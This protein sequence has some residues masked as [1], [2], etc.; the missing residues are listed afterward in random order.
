M[1]QTD[2]IGVGLIGYGLGGQACHAPYIRS[3]AGM[4]LQAVVS[5]DAAKIPADMPDTL[6]VPS[7]DALLSEPGIGLVVIS[8]PDDLH[9]EHALAA[10]RA[11]KHV[12]IDK[13]FATTLTDAQKVATEAEAQGRL[14]TIFHNRRWDADFLTLRRLL[15]EGTLGDIVQFES[16]FDRWRPVPAATWKE[17]REAGSWQDLGPDLVDQA[18]QLFGMPAGISADIVTLREGASAPHCFHVTLRYPRIRVLLHS[19]KLVAEHGLRFAVRGTRGKWAK[20]GTDPQEAATVAG[21]LPQGDWGHDPVSGMFTD[22]NGVASEIANER[23][24]YRLF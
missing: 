11:G 21:K 6:V 16:H 15:R 14:L 10:L 22:A 24:D 3:T 4:S 1:T 17:S 13:P 19:S 7:I 20:Y 5:R 18:L 9:A 23:S 2:D 8:S 12:L